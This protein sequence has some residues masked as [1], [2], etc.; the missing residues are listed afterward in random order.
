MSLPCQA[1]V[2]LCSFS[3][4]ALINIFVELLYFRHWLVSGNTA[5]N[6][7]RSLLLGSLYSNGRNSSYSYK[8]L[9]VI[10]LGAWWKEQKR[11]SSRERS[12]KWGERTELFTFVFPAAGTMEA[13]NNCLSRRRWGTSS[14]KMTNLDHWATGKKINAEPQ[15]WRGFIHSPNQAKYPP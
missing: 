12:E 13:F 9:K 2:S 4:I 15:M 1:C 5:E 7:T 3:F 6:D 14:G 11:Q 8:W 10:G